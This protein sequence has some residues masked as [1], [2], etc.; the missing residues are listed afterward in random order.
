[1]APRECPVRCRDATVLVPVAFH[2]NY[3]L[4]GGA[5][6]LVDVVTYLEVT[7]AHV[8]N[9]QLLRRVPP[10]AAV[11]VVLSYE[12][13]PAPITDVCHLH[14]HVE[15]RGAHIYLDLLLCGQIQREVV[16]AHTA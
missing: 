13:A 15:V 5:T 3:D 7:R 9:I 8:F 6:H 16:E 11:V 14:N 10:S 4:V 12:L 1:V 2:L